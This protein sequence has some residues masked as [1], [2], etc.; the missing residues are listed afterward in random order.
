MDAP[1]FRLDHTP[2]YVGK[3]GQRADSI[4]YLLPEDVYARGTGPGCM[5][6][7]SLGYRGDVAAS[8]TLVHVSTSR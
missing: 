8:F 1:G 5:A 2:P 4:N 3:E 7:Y 6:N